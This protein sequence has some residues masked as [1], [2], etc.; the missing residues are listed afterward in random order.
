MPCFDEGTGNT[1]DLNGIQTAPLSNGEQGQGC[2]KG[3]A[4]GTALGFNIRICLTVRRI[5][6][7]APPRPASP[8]VRPCPWIQV[9][10]MTITPPPRISRTPR[11]PLSPCS[12]ATY[13]VPRF[14]TANILRT[15]LN[16]TA[17]S[18]MPPHFS[19]LLRIQ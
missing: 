15:S 11:I 4:F 13:G 6:P 5:L 19:F 10:T 17:L 12:R 1:L 16:L 7:A 9:S 14:I 18:T 2:Y 8:A 3:N